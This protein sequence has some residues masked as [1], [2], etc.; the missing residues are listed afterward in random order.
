MEDDEEIDN[1]AMNALITSPKSPKPI[2][3]QSFIDDRSSPM[4][5]PERYLPVIQLGAGDPI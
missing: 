3:T 4:F 1:Y 5:E 2:D